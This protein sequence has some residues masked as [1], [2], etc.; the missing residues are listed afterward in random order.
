MKPVGFSLRKS[1]QK[2]ESQ[3][4]STHKKDRWMLINLIYIKADPSLIQ[5]ST[6][7]NINFKLVKFSQ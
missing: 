3:V 1:K 6:V 4:G 2:T 5:S 7:R